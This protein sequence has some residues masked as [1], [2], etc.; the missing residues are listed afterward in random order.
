MDWIKVIV[1][2][3]NWCCRQTDMLRWL[4]WYDTSWVY[5]RHLT[6]TRHRK[7]PTTITKIMCRWWWCFRE[8]HRRLRDI[9]TM[10]QVRT[11]CWLYYFF[12]AILLRH[13]LI[14]FKLDTLFLSENFYWFLPA[15][16]PLLCSL[17]ESGARGRLASPPELSCSQY[18]C[19][20]SSIA[21][22]SC[23]S[24]M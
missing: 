6:T 19:G 18:Q 24:K 21:P 3:E 23:A 13:I 2:V 17:V 9:P 15:G 4:K 20:C 12:A 16:L 22:G 7:P 10:T 8:W 1:C 14:F 11:T 5:I